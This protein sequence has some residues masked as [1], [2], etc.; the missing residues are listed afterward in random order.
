MKNQLSLFKL[1]VFPF[2]ANYKYVTSTNIVACVGR[3]NHRMF[4]YTW[5]K[6][7][8]DLYNSFLNV[9]HVEE[10]QTTLCW[11]RKGVVYSGIAFVMLL[12]GW[13]DH[14]STVFCQREVSL[15]NLWKYP[16]DII[17]AYYFK[18]F[19][20]GT[21]VLRFYFYDH[22]FLEPSTVLGSRTADTRFELVFPRL[23]VI[24]IWMK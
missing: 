20:G 21:C 9:K 7:D 18:L 11:F 22:F 2:F 1:V 13:S 5:Q 6:Y 4:Q 8:E 16:A 17:S 24:Q 3:C 12:P 14:L 10:E 23:C 19:V 15:F